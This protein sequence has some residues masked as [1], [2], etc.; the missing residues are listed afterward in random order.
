MRYVGSKIIDK[1]FLIVSAGMPGLYKLIVYWFVSEEYGLSVLGELSAEFSIAQIIG[2]VTALGYCAIV[3]VNVSGV[4]ENLKNKEFNILKSESNFIILVLTIISAPIVLA[5]GIDKIHYLN[6]VLMVVFWGWYQLA[7]HY[8]FAR[9]SYRDIVFSD[10]VV[11]FVTVLVIHYGLHPIYGLILGHVLGFIALSF[12]SDLN[13]IPGIKKPDHV[14][15]AM[16]YSAGNLLSN[17]VLI[18]IPV[19]AAQW[20]DLKLAGFISLILSLMNI[21]T[22]LPRAL[23]LERIAGLSMTYRANNGLNKTE[24][25]DKSI[26]YINLV[27]VFLNVVVA[28][29][30]S[31]I[32]DINLN[33][34]NYVI[35][36]GIATYLYFN[37]AGLKAANILMVTKN[38]GILL[39]TN[40][41]SV[42][43]Y[44]VICLLSIFFI[45]EY[46]VYMLI[47]AINLST[48]IR[49]MATEK[50]ALKI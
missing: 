19:F 16:K 25:K 42:F 44:G 38:E 28:C 48:I 36:V 14:G 26:N 40:M 12:I 18:S 10:V 22:L 39:R 49:F 2:F 35:M 46:F 43:V 7:R 30:Y 45:K 11:L 23:A 34:D 3:L 27:L 5:F 1:L 13:L 20:G 41:V 31:Y 17:G 6:T 29:V 50:V 47:F 8:C 24:I 32:T 33:L 21:A 37:N 9:K 4:E 15:S